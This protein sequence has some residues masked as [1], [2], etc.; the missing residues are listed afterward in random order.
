M[1][2]WRWASAAAAALLF[3]VAA[4]SEVMYPGDPS[5]IQDMTKQQAWQKG[6]DDALKGL[7]R[8]STNFELGDNEDFY[9]TGYDGGLA[10]KRDPSGPKP[11]F[12]DD[13]G[14]YNPSPRDYHPPP[15]TQPPSATGGG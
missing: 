11:T 14:R 7:P 13:P 9:T 1:Q 6:F 8:A 5:G 15:Y 12:V 3:L 10:Y 2:G 4:C